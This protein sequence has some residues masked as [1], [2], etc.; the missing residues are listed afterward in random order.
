MSLLCRRRRRAEVTA[1]ALPSIGGVGKHKDMGLYTS[2]NASDKE[3]DDEHTTSTHR[4]HALA[5]SHST[6]AHSSLPSIGGGGDELPPI[7]GKSALMAMGRSKAVAAAA[8]YHTYSLKN[9]PT[10]GSS[11]V[12]RSSHHSQVSGALARPTY[13]DAHWELKRR[14]HKHRVP[15]GTWLS[16]GAH[17]QLGESPR[18]HGLASYQSD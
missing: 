10:V 12:A 3:N 9:K 15:S 1:A 4:A 2:S 11:S 6:H 13:H 8:N 5:P 18:S 16:G 17:P 14:Q 7:G